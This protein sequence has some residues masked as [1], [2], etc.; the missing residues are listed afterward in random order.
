[1]SEPLSFHFVH[2]VHAH[3]C[4]KPILIAVLHDRG[5]GRILK[6]GSFS[7]KSRIFTVNFTD[8]FSLLRTF[9]VN[10]KDLSLF[11]LCPKDRQTCEVGHI[12]AYV[13]DFSTATNG[14]TGMP[15]DGSHMQT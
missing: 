9:T 8:F 14:Y 10:F 11:Q 13:V 4:A 15:K 3:V 2:A 5:V 7:K 6:A 12:L 1:V